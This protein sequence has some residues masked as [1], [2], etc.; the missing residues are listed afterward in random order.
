MIIE[1]EQGAKCLRIHLHCS[2]NCNSEDIIETKEFSMKITLP[3]LTACAVVALL[4]GCTTAGSSDGATKSSSALSEP[5]SA[6]VPGKRPVLTTE[7]PSKPVKVAIIAIENNPFFA[8]VKTGFTA[9]AKKIKAA[10]GQADWINAGT[11]VNVDNV[12]NAINAAVTQGYDAIAALMPGDGICSYVKS[13][14]DA[15][16]LIAAYNG[17][18]SCAQKSGAIFFHGQDLKAAG[19]EA[20][21]LM[22]KATSTIASKDKPGKVGIETESFTFQALEDRRNGFLEAVKAKCPWVTP[23]NDGIEYQGSTDRIASSTRDFMTSTPDLVGIYVTGGN[24]NIAAQTVRDASKQSTVKVIGFDFTAENVVQIKAGSMYASIDQDPYG[25]S[26]D[27]LVW[28]YNAVVTHQK[29]SPDYF[30][31]TNAVV[32]TQDTIDTLK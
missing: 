21:K 22:C 18:A 15:G 8:Q 3:I 23:V 9:A 25:Q 10:G 14:A 30:I 5:A 20:G 12:G 6:P 16:V 1:R 17:N 2:P 29:P 32:G 26:F 7:K 28:L 19:Q 11:E 4:A 31:P 13:A 24:P 27:S